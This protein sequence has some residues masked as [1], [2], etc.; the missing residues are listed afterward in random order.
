M[1]R[2]SRILAAGVVAALAGSAHATFHLIQIE[3]IIGGVNGDTTAQAIQIR[4]RAAGQHLQSQGR[5]RVWD[6]N[7]ANPIVIIDQASN[8]AGPSQ[9]GDHV[10]FASANFVSHLDAPI[11]V[12]YT[13][14]N[15]I[16]ESYLAA[17]SLTFET[18]S[19]SV[20]Y[21]RVSWGGASY[22][23]SNAGSV[24]NDPDGNFGPPWPGPLPSEGVQALKFQGIATA[25][26]ANNAADYA[27]TAGAAVFTNYSELSATLLE[28]EVTGACC[29]TDGSCAEDSTAEACAT[30]GGT[31]QGDGSAC[32]KVE[33][34]QP[35]ECPA[36][37]VSASTFQPPPDGVVDGAD[38][39]FLL[40]EWGPARGSLADFVSASTFQP[41]PDGI[42]DAADLAFLLGSWGPCD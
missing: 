32:A 29:M 19:G 37:T 28:P 2:F 31:F 17:G 14:T 8:L 1:H 3:Q 5:F 21:W 30:A 40:G 26:S 39:A 6:A 23:G 7:G 42:V 13:L 25:A 24:T 15:L 27:L 9:A 11:A 35:A 34:P 41:P 33:C 20:I 4:F 12:N 36:D 38:L 18:D 22:T 16:P 10:L